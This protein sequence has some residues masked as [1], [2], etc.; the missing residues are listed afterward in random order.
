MRREFVAP[1]CEVIALEDRLFC[2]MSMIQASGGL[3][4]DDDS[5]DENL[6]EKMGR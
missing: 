6:Y 5:D 4:D 3:H 2:Q 1:A